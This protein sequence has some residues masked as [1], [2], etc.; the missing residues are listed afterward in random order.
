MNLDAFTLYA[1]L[2]TNAGTAP[3]KNVESLIDQVTVL[4]NG[5]DVA[6]GAQMT[7]F[8]STALI[9]FYG[10]DKQA[11]RTLCQLGADVVQP[12]NASTAAVVT[13][14]AISHFLDFLSSA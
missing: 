14:I 1:N 10:A 5:I 12:A 4:V 13:P 8:L 7:N 2:T 9:D 6:P 3:P 11:Q